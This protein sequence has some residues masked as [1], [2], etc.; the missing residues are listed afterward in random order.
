M[1]ASWMVCPF[2]MAKRSTFEQLAEERDAAKLVAYIPIGSPLH[3]RNVS[4]SLY[5][6]AFTR[7]R[8]GVKAGR[9]YIGTDA[10]KAILE[11]AW[12]TVQAEIERAAATPEGR[13]LRELQELA[14]GPPLARTNAERPQ[15]IAVGAGRGGP[16]RPK[17]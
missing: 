2:T 12:A 8:P 5:W 15:K 16:R 10:N 4:G 3:Q 1:A 14:G 7:E 13:R 17:R 6:Y 9:C 11:A